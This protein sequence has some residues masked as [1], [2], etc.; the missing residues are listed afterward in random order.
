MTGYNA[1]Y[2]FNWINY[3]DKRNIFVN[4]CAADK[5]DAIS[6]L[7]GIMDPG[8]AISDKADYMASVFEREELGTTGLGDSVAM[9]H[10]KSGAV[11]KMSV[12]L[13]K[14]SQPMDFESI[15]NSPVSYIFLIA[16]PLNADTLY[17]KVMASIIRSVK[18]H[19][20]C[21]KM[22]TLESPGE[23]YEMLLKTV[24]E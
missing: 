15:D 18:I 11:K 9:P 4:F 14:L 3:L 2:D 8:E 22:N 17:I 10:G 7:I 21:E 19:R 20:I 24:I 23:I 12:A 13:A 5:H 16:S 6:K 1:A